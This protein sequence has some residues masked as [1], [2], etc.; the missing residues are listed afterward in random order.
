MD[1]DSLENL[2]ENQIDKMFNE[3]TKDN[4]VI[5]W[6]GMIA[7]RFVPVPPRGYGV[8]IYNPD[9]DFGRYTTYYH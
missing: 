4:S 9:S 2:D 8:I 5:I 6:P 1:F 3:T 7:A